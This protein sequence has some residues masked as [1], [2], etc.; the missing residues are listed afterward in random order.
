MRHTDRTASEL[1]R[2]GFKPFFKSRQLK[3]VGKHD[4]VI[5][6]FFWLEQG[7]HFP[8]GVL[9]TCSVCKA[10]LQIRPET[11]TKAPKL[12]VFCAVDK[13]LQDYWATKPKR[14]AKAPSS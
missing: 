3:R 9:V 11:N 13:N 7:L 6:G 5:G 12:C 1:A 14:G 4:A 2:L 8:D 10:A